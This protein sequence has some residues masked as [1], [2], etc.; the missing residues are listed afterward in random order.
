MLNTSREEH[1]VGAGRFAI[2]ELEAYV[3][4]DWYAPFTR[5]NHA[6]R[7][8]D[9][10]AERGVERPQ[11]AS[12]SAAVSGDMSLSTWRYKTVDTYC[13]F[14]ASRAWWDLREGRSRCRKK[15]SRGFTDF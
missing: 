3:P 1:V 6:R 7:V 11:S 5:A 4:P 12:A 15:S 8:A 2:D 10:L 13:G 14:R 9:Q